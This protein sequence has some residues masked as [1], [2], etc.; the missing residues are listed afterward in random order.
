M[1]NQQYSEVVGIFKKAILNDPEF[2]PAYYQAGKSSVISHTGYE[3]E[4]LFKQI[5][6]S[7]QSANEI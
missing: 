1:D 5:P 7:N 6:I 2:M 4:L 3:I